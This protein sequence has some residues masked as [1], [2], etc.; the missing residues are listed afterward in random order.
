M[1]SG[2]EPSVTV[3]QNTADV[4]NQFAADW[5]AGP[6]DGPETIDDELYAFAGKLVGEVDE[7]SAVSA[8]VR[9]STR[10]KKHTRHS[11]NQFTPAGG[12]LIP[13]GMLSSYEVHAFTVPPVLNGN[14]EEL[15]EYLYG[16]FSDPGGSEALADRWSVDEDVFEFFAKWDYSSEMFGVP[17]DGNI[18]ARYVNVE[19]ES[20]GYETVGSGPLTPITVPHDYDEVLPST[21]LNFSLSEDYILRFGLARVMA[22]P[23]LDELRAGRY[24]DDPVSTP[25]PLTAW[26]GN[27]E[28]DPFL[29]W[30]FDVSSEWYFAPESMFAAAFYYKDVD[31]HIGY[32]TVPIQVDGYTYAL[33]G[34]ANGDGG[35]IQ[36][37]EFTLL[38]PFSFVTAL[39]NFGIYSNYA[40]IDSDVQEFYPW[41]DPLD[42]SGI[43]ENTATVDLWYSG[44]RFEARL[45]YKY[46]SEY[47]LIY[48]WTGSDVRT[49]ESEG[50]LGLSLSYQ[51]TYNWGTR[52][53][54]NNLTDEPLRV[55]RDND[56]DRLGR[57]DEYGRYYLVDVTFSF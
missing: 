1:R 42:A 28:L 37:V 5:L 14:F 15:A 56:P 16:G 45:G 6:H 18:G 26:G 34:P 24:R 9:L 44:E 11:W 50:I 13:A 27:P 54:V 51:F 32:S 25:P 31:T 8:G 10:E 21:S 4:N 33:S 53:Q 35:T 38:A 12:L 23:P 29:A 20:F 49:L 3:S 41:W 52:F 55:Y 30:Q 22:R 19:T 36:G 2:V 47:T 39:E 40:Y 48:G 43:A 7:G 46:H 57:Y 17:V